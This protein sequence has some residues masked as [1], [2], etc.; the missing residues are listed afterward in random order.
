MANKKHLGIL[1][2]GTIAWN[3]W[4]KENREIKPNL[5]PSNLAIHRYRDSDDLVASLREK[6][7]GAAQSKAKE[8]QK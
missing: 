8:L 1:K 6:V 3:R 4:R 7:I 2:Q 5:S